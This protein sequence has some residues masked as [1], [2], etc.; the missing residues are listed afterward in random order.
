VLGG[1]EN[2]SLKDFE[3]FRA[4]APGGRGDKGSRETSSLRQ[5]EGSVAGW[6]DML[7][8]PGQAPSAS[9][10]ELGPLGRA[11]GLSFSGCQ[12]GL[13]SRNW[14][15]GSS[16]GSQPLLAALFG[17]SAQGLVGL[18]PHHLPAASSWLFHP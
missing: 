12:S 8:V 14:F 16:P 2:Q 11:A 3:M 7:K 10:S 15:S 4:E 18:P 6:E 9:K 5:G 17:E 13:G 1:L